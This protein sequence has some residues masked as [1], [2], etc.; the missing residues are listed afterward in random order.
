M[1]NYKQHHEQQLLEVFHGLDVPATRIKEAMHYALFPG[2][3]RLRAVLTYLCGELFAVPLAALDSIAIAV[4]MTHCY[5]LVHDDLPAMDNDDFRRGKA[6]CHRA[7][8]EATAILV[9]DG[10]QALAIELL[11]ERLPEYLSPLQVIGITK[12]LVAACGPSGMVSGQS[13]DLSEL[14]QASITEEDL[15]RIHGLKTG[16]L[17]EACVNMVLIAATPEPVLESSLREFGRILGLVFQMQ[18]DYLDHYSSDDR[19]G[20]GRSSDA[21]NRKLTFA[22]LYPQEALF[23]LI[24]NQIQQAKNALRCFGD[25]AKELQQLLEDLRHRME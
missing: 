13:L 9:G 12:A 19:L 5:S 1:N 22:S 11:L 14:S 15:R 25:R 4:E 3:K 16:K 17:L 6:S 18:D 10:L 8:D 23:A 20:K 24:I 21:A 7:F 2:G